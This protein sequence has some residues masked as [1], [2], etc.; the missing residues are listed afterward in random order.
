MTATSV[1]GPTRPADPT[2]L[3][4]PG[5]A[6]DAS[7]IAPFAPGVLLRLEGL[8]LLA[9]S[10]VGYA[11]LDASWLLFAALFLLPDLGML[12][13]LVS[14]RFGAH[15]YNATHWLL[16][17]VALA[18]IG[19]TQ[20]PVLLP[21]ALIWTAHIGFDRAL[22]YGLKYPTSFKDTHLQRIA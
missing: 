3:D 21:Y 14:M 19:V 9:A 7:P 13:Y 16:V 11:Y 8:A 5:M 12:G 6:R 17:P 15:V 10:V 4:T 18:G 22:G 2:S 20:A 1:G